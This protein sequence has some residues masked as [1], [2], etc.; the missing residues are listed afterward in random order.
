MLIYLS[1]E[2]RD[3]LFYERTNLR[4]L[5]HDGIV[6]SLSKIVKANIEPLFISQTNSLNRV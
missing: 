4:A 3:I 1:G 5:G 6:D 2:S